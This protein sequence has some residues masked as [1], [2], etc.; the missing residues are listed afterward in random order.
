M[1]DAN[2]RA[3]IGANAPPEPMDPLLAI[4][5]EYDDTFAEVANWLDGGKVENESQMKA[6]DDL[7]SA[8]KDAEKAAIDAKEIEYRPHKAACDGVVSRWKLFLADLDRQR[9][10][11]IAAQDV[12][13][14]AL[15]AEKETARKDAERKAWDATEAARKAAEAAAPT[16]LD[17]QREAAVMAEAAAVAQKASNA[18]KKDVVKGMRT[19]TIREIVDGKACINWIAQNDKP[20]LLAFMQ[21]YVDRAPT[22]IPGVNER[23]EKVPT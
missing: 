6:V 11:L 14:R 8:V 20:A 4:Q 1:T 17:S 15:A 5:A 13:K 7:L 22:V 23:K 16:D 3:V 18:A 12:F 2:P 10:G 21:A 9:K 19:V